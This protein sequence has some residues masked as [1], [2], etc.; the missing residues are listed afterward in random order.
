MG[1]TARRIRLVIEIFDHNTGL[2]RPEILSR[3]NSREVIDRR[4]HRLLKSGQIR[5]DGTRMS[6]WNPS[7]L[8][9][10]TVIA[11]LKWILRESEL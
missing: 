10:S 3:Y 2:T 7:V 1:E 6:L 4:I 9:M 8:L 5:T 11:W